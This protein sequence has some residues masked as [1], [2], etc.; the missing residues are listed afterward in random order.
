MAKTVHVHLGPHKT[1]STAIQAYLD[2]HA[3]RL[4]AAH[5]LTVVD[6]KLVIDLAF[7][8]INGKVD[9]QT[10]CI[11]KIAAIVAAAPGDCII[12]CEDLSGPLPGRTMKSRIYPGVWQNIK[13]I[14]RGLPGLAC[15]F[16]FF[17]R[18]PESW[19]RSA[20]AQHVQ[21]R[22]RFNSFEAFSNHFNTS[23][24][25]GSVLQRSRNRL[26]QNLIEI[27]YRADADYS[28]INALMRAILGPDA[29]FEGD[30]V[31]LRKN[32]SPSEEG[33]KIIELINTSGASD[34]AKNAAKRV[35]KAGATQPD[36]LAD[37]QTFPDWPPDVFRPDWLSSGLEALWGRAS[38]R[39][40]E[41]SQPMLLPERNAD[42]SD[43]RLRAVEAPDDFPEGKRR[44]MHNQLEILAHRFRGYPEICVLLGLSI[45]YLR[46]ST[47]HNDHAAFIFQRLWAEEHEILLGTLSTRWLISSFQTFM[48]HGANEDQRLIGASAYFMSNTLK[49]YE[50]ERALEGAKPNAVYPQTSPQTKSGFKGMDR[51]PL[52]GSDIMLNTNAILLE[53]SA[54]DDIAGRV[55]QEF[56]LRLKAA[57][58][59][60]SRMD[61]SRQYHEIDVPQ[62]TNCWSFFEEP[63][64]D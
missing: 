53:L 15:K 6:R 46:R 5:S 36:L 19:L 25:W 58:T 60:F 54:R 18:E 33:I 12:T 40:S 44:H 1:G 13:K 21:H 9:A 37:D 38:R 24:L 52:G 28:S 49:M 3:D 47:E 41:Q 16:Y 32:T 29:T 17:V 59:L 10:D 61:R 48:D 20:Y 27:E 51:F 45:S 8:M 62:F 34:T 63:D 50:A 56:M 30:D 11:Q 23:N 22:S 4:K 64:R 42:L 39:V 31:M 57:D 55:V 35:I 14:Q 2:A 43:Y 7:A 26:E